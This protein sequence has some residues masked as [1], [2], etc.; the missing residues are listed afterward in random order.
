MNILENQDEFLEEIIS[1]K[2]NLINSLREIDFEK[3]RE[4]Y[5]GRYSPERFKEFF[6]EKIS[7]HMVFKYILIRM[8]EETMKKVNV[9]LN[10][11]GLKK[12]YE[13]SKNFRR[14]YSLLYELSIIDVKREDGVK[15]I[16]RDSTYDSEKFTKKTTIVF[17]QY[18]SLL[19]KY[20]FSGIDPNLLMTLIEHIYDSS[21]RE[22]LQGFYEHSQIINFLLQEVGLE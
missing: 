19:S 15:D 8:V 21:K 10:D 22:E 7:I 6:I 12:W 2:D 1:F 14:D 17:N 18:I 9:K 13:M 3:Y 11:D 20:D 4:D 16:F 5:K